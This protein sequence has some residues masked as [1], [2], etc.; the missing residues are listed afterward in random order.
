MPR[1]IR[2]DNRTEELLHDD[3]GKINFQLQE[4]AWKA[5][6]VQLR[7]DLGLP[8]GEI[9]W[10][11]MCGSSCLLIPIERCFPQN[12]SLVYPSTAKNSL[13]LNLAVIVQ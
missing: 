7:R 8:P 2:S 13:A 11:A 9:G 5:S 1:T 6:P 10:K 3:E 4:V 12:F